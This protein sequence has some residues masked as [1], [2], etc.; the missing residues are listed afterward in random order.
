MR[1]T[2]VPFNIISESLTLAD[3]TLDEISRL[4]HQHTE[5]TGQ[6]FEENAIER[7]WY[8]TEGQPWLVN[9][10]A[11]QIEDRKRWPA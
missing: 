3:F 2:T 11:R 1:G 7:A 9:A 5:A 4:Y 6:A 8:W 10:L